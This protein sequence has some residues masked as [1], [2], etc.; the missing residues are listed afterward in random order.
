MKACHNLKNASQTFSHVWVMS[1]LFNLSCI[2]DN[3]LL[4]REGYGCI[5][6]DKQHLFNS[7]LQGNG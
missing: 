7:D 5:M 3:V 4:M 1:I 2:P 6:F